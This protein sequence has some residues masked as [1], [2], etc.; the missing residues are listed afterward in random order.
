MRHEGLHGRGGRGGVRADADRPG[1]ASTWRRWRAPS[2]ADGG[3]RPCRSRGPTSRPAACGPCATASRWARARWPPGGRSARR[4]GGPDADRVPRAR[5]RTTPSTRWRTSSASTGGSAPSGRWWRD[6]LRA[7]RRRAGPLLDVGC[8]TG[9][10][11]GGAG[12]ARRAVGAELDDRASW[13]LAAPPGRRPRRALVRAAADRRPGAR[14]RGRRSSPPSTSSSTSTTTSPRSASWGAS[15][16]DGLVVVA[17]PAY[18]WAWSDHDVR[19]GHRRRYTRRLADRGGPRR[20]PR[21]APRDLL[22]QLAGA[23]GPAPPAHAAAT[24]AP[25]QRGG[26]ELRQPGGEPPP[27]ARSPVPSG[28]GCAGSTCPLGLSLLLVARPGPPRPP[29]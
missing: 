27:R 8:G 6:Q 19:L 2:G 28:P 29:G 23:A 25:G 16:G 13:T 3:S 7:V 17:V 5:W 21:G 15:A 26:G 10:S 9:G 14:R 18:L 11:A 24:A 12:R 1:S 20:G 4:S 22:P